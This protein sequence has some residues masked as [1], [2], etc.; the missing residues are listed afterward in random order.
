[1][2]AAGVL[3]GH[4]ERGAGDVG[5][6]KTTARRAVRALEQQGVA[7]EEFFLSI[8]DASS[9]FPMKLPATSG[10]SVRTPQSSPL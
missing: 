3:T 1:M 8:S 5:F 7:W 9:S 4:D 6:V 10:N 2:D